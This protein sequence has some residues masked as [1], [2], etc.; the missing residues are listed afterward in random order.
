MKRNIKY[1]ILLL[2]FYQSFDIYAQ[3]VKEGETI[4]INIKD[5]RIIRQRIIIGDSL[6]N[7]YRILEKDLNKKIDIKDSLLSL[8]K[9]DYDNSL[10]LIKNKDE[11]IIKQDFLF[12]KNEEKYKS[13]LK[14]Y[15]CLVALG[16]TIAT[17]LILK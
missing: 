16:S 6:I 12:T 3:I 8:S 7:Y 9:K 14:L 1:L 10:V 4:K 5:Y 15:T 13:N 17:I 2:L 11:Y